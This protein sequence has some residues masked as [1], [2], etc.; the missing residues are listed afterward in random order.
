MCVCIYIYIYVQAS[1][2][3]YMCTRT[4]EDMTRAEESG[5]NGERAHRRRLAE[6]KCPAKVSA[7][8]IASTANGV[9]FVLVADGNIVHSNDVNP[10]EML[11]AMMA[12]PMLAAQGLE[13]NAASVQFMLTHINS[14]S[15]V[16]KAPLPTMQSLNG[17]SGGKTVPADG[18]VPA[19]GLRVEL[20]KPN[21]NAL[22]AASSG[23]APAVSAENRDEVAM[24]DIE[25]SEDERAA[26]KTNGQLKED[27]AR[28][29]VKVTATTK[30]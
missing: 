2:Y 14:K 22:L 28:P 9:A 19:E 11:Q 6:E 18:Q 25:M 13:A 5:G 17:S 15:M 26:T 29:V 7:A 23:L 30:R 4:H 8:D 10:D 24:V 16:V 27:A 3:A 12:N 21:A 20:V 1:I